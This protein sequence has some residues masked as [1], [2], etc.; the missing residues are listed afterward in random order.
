MIL[1]KAV[2][3]LLIGLLL[4][5]ISE[6]LKEERTLVSQ[7]VIMPTLL[8]YLMGKGITI[9]IPH[10][11][12]KDFAVVFDE[13]P[14]LKP[15]ERRLIDDLKLKEAKLRDVEIK[16]RL[17]DLSPVSLGEG[18]KEQA[19]Q[20]FFV[21]DKNDLHCRIKSFRIKAHLKI[22]R[23]GRDI[24]GNKLPPIKATIDR[25]ELKDI[26]SLFSFYLVKSGNSYYA[27]DLALKRMVLSPKATVKIRE[28]PPIINKII[29][30][31]IGPAIA[32][33]GNKEVLNDAFYREF[34]A[35]LPHRIPESGS[36]SL[37]GILRDI[38][39]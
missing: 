39:N 6:P 18:G 5:G 24:F 36:P 21:N 11:M 16:V 23:K 19:R 22:T 17:D 38:L 10:Y 25:F 3:S 7:E 30:D 27:E 28:F 1:R 32:D 8:N 2:L 15:E 34:N 14:D 12:E 29:S 20:H 35:N 4:M 9:K 26:D 31:I 37:L 33:I 13:L